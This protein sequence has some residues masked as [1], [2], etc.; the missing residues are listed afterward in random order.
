MPRSSEGG[1]PPAGPKGQGHFFL[2][3]CGK[4]RELL[5]QVKNEDIAASSVKL[6]MGLHCKVEPKEEVKHELKR[7]LCDVVKQEMMGRKR[8]RVKSEPDDD[9]ERSMKKDVKEEPESE[10]AVL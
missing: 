1:L 2:C 4:Q 3:G 10:D 6:E 7:E 5:E 9:D 8:L